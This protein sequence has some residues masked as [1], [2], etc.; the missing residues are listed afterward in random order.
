[1]PQ[2]DGPE[3]RGELVSARS[4]RSMSWSATRRRLALRRTPSRRR[5]ARPP[6]HGVAPRSVAP[7]QQEA[8][9]REQDDAVGEEAEQAHR[10]HGGDADV[11]AA[12]VVGVPQDIA[13]PGLHRDHLGHDHR[14]P[15]HAD[16]EPQ[17][18]EDGRQRRGK[19]DLGQHGPGAGPQHARGAQQQQ[20]GV[21]HAVR[22]VDHDGVEGAEP[23]EEQ[24]A[25]VIDAEDGDGE[26]Q[27]GGD[28]HRAQQLD[29][30]D[31]PRRAARRFQP[32]KMPSGMPTA[33]ARR[34]PCEHAARRVEH[35]GHPG[36][37]IGREP[38][39]RAAPK[40]QRVPGLRPPGL[41][42][43]MMPSVTQRCSHRQVPQREQAPAAAAG[44]RAR[45]QPQLTHRTA[46]ETAAPLGAPARGLGRGS[47]RCSTAADLADTSRAMTPL[48]ERNLEM[49]LIDSSGSVGSSRV[50]ADGLGGHRLGQA[51]L[52]GVDLGP[53]LRVGLARELEHVHVRDHQP[54]H[55]VAVLLHEAAVHR[56]HGDQ[57]AHGLGPVVV[58]R[59]VLGRSRPRW[60]GRRRAATPPPCRSPC[61]AAPSGSCRRRP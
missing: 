45:A 35:V 12:H 20:V 57:P 36:A 6:P 14:R 26:R 27:P 28:G 8:R 21:A 38:I 46:F 56:Q 50:S 52:L 37:R 39:A 43:G 29:R 13:Q 40:I 41:G 42:D 30:W 25:R 55:R 54:L 34:K 47:R 60:P 2:P 7:A 5:A 49:R 24:G 4:R 33:A 10:E 3:E 23:D 18:G 58:E 59:R 31:R 17:A 44:T 22:G 1:M 15:G 32:M 16:A 11:H 51:G 48:S 61:P 53:A 9:A 19:H